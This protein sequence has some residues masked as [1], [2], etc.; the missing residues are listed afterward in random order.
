MNIGIIGAG[1]LGSAL[2]R[3]LVAVGHDVMI[4]N[5]RGAAAVEG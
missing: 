2:A 5:W 3:R 1:K 4:S